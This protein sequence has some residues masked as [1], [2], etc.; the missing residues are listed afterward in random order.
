MA[1][2]YGNASNRIGSFDAT[3]DY[4]M[5]DAPLCLLRIDGAAWSASEAL[6]HYHTYGQAAGRS[7]TERFLGRTF[8]ITNLQFRLRH[9]A[10]GIH[11]WIGNIELTELGLDASAPLQLQENS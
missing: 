2:A 4:Y 6:D 7:T 5:H 11:Q 3:D 1:V 10:D 9:T 8:T